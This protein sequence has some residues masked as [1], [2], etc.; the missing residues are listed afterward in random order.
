MNP[1]KVCMPTTTF[2]RWPG[3]GEGAFVWGLARALARQGAEVDIVALHSPGSDT[4]EEF[5]GLTVHRPKYWWPEQQE[6]LRKEQAG[7]PITLRKYRLARLQ[8]L[9][10]GLIHTSKIIQI[11]RG[12]DVIHAHWTLSAGTALPGHWMYNRPLIATVQGSDIF[13]VTQHPIG[14]W[15][16]R[17]ILTRCSAV[18]TLSQAL[19]QATTVAAGMPADKI[20]IIPNG[21]DTSE[22]VPPSDPDERDP[23]I[24]FVGSLIPRKGVT[25]FLEALVKFFIQMPGYQALILG[26]GSQQAALETQ[27]RQLGIDHKIKFAGFVSQEQIRYAMRKAKLLVLPSL[28]EGQGVVLLEAL[29]SGTP[30]VA[31]NVGGIPD[32]VTSD[33]GYLVAPADP[34]GLSKGMHTLLVNTEQWQAMSK[35]ARNRAVNF[36]DWQLIS[37]KFLDVY[38]DLIQNRNNSGSSLP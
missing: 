38:A 11:A 3:D 7:L 28:E 36:Y 1:I 4:Y 33:V 34:I 2:P 31:S 17:Q 30:I 18:T 26:G 32:V 29:A 35:A 13:Q 14:A 25:Y 27:A 6:L 8:L 23:L 22:F 12:A 21:V 15:F 24:L 9:P 10:F 5:D 16:T 37:K 19:C 20:H